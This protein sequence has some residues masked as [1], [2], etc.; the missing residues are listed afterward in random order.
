MRRNLLSLL[1]A[2][3]AAI[4]I[5]ASSV[6]GEPNA[7]ESSPRPRRAPEQQV[8]SQARYV[9][10]L[11]ASFST[12]EKANEL[13]SRLR[14]NYP[15]AY[16][17]SPNASETLY[18]VRVGPYNS[19]DDAEQVANDLA[20]EGFAGVTI[21]PWR[22]STRKPAAEPTEKAVL[23]TP[24]QE[25]DDA[26]HRAI[27]NLSTQ[28]G[29]LADEMRLFR[30]DTQLNSAMMELLLNEDRLA[31]V[32]DKIQDVANNKAQLDAREQDIARRSR[33]IQGELLLRGGLRRDEAET[34]IRADL[35]RALDDVHS[36]QAVYQQRTAELNEQATRLRARG[37]T[38]R[39]KIELL[40]LKNEKQEKE[41]K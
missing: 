30:R 10:Q 5:S 17:E 32:E 7:Q 31:K 13:A 14:R 6:T 38:L 16:T 27:T 25:P 26:I 3:M 1:L 37:E 19:R 35:Q 40:D 23:T 33:N 2:V 9:V 22:Q 15:S 4:A 18:R 41:E 39:K 34:A 8:S 21:L 12:A 24:I 20:G 28:I 11:G 29:L 36:Q